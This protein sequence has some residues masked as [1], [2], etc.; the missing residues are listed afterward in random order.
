MPRKLQNSAGIEYQD[1][2]YAVGGAEKR[3]TSASGWI[4]TK[5]IYKFDNIQWKWTTLVGERLS[6]YRG[7]T[8][9]F[10]VDDTKFP[11]C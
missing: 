11:P 3:T 6:N 8:T 5:I 10:L 1:T 9:A 2:L 7:Y 4:Y